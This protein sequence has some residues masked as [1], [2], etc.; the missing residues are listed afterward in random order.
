MNQPSLKAQKQV[1]PKCH[2]QS[3]DCNTVKTSRVPVKLCNMSAK[4]VTLPPKSNMCELQE[5]KLLR[6]LPLNNTVGVTAHVN[7]Q[8]VEKER[9]R[10]L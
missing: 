6:S 5:V 9:S 8:N 4:I 10:H 2:C 1:L 7:Q 3:E